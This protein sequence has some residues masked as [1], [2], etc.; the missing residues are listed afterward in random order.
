[1]AE[2]LP[3]LSSLFEDQE[4]TIV[5]KPIAYGILSKEFPVIIHDVNLLSYYFHVSPFF[6]FLF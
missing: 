6:I 4:S 1:M 5:F 2:E 3:A